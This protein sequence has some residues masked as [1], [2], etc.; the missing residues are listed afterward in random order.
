MSITARNVEKNSKN[1]C[2]L[3]N[4]MRYL[5]ALIAKAKRLTRNSPCSVRQ[6]CLVGMAVVVPVARAVP[7]VPAAVD[8]LD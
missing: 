7:A 4:Q 2:R 1:V 6:A 5:S 8:E 3:P